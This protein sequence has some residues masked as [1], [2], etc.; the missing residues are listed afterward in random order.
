MEFVYTQTYIILT[1]LAGNS[2]TISEATNIKS[3]GGLIHPNQGFFKLILAI[4]DS[5]EKYCNSQH[6]FQNCV[7]DV[8]LKSGH[9]T[10]FPCSE[11]KTEIMIYNITYYENE[12]THSITK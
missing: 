2:S 8:L 1:Y 12:T 4:E 9:L 3:K 7:D 10:G 11:H 5:F 6:V